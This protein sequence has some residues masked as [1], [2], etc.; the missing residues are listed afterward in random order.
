[1]VRTDS[2][3]WK[4]TWVARLSYVLL[5]VYISYAFSFVFWYSWFLSL[6]ICLYI[7]CNTR[8]DIGCDGEY[9]FIYH[10]SIVSFL[11]KEIKSKIEDIYSINYNE[12]SDNH[13]VFSFIKEYLF[14]QGLNE[15]GIE[16]IYKD[17]SCTFYGMPSFRKEYNSILKQVNEMLLD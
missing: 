14:K 6:P 13:E 5:L 12:C 7:I 17:D 8:V 9:V 1:M 10:S 3:Y 11:N 2:L 16:I 15:F 4:S